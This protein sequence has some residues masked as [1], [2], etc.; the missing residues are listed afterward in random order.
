MFFR[1][2]AT[3]DSVRSMALSFR[4]GISTTSKIIRETCK[5]IW[6]NM[7]HEFFT[8]SKENWLHIEEEFAQRWNFPHCVGAVDGKH[9]VI[10]VRIFFQMNEKF[11]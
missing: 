11:L 7:Q 2:L 9:V 1:Y 6:F 4:V 8:P 3:G 10:M 5:V